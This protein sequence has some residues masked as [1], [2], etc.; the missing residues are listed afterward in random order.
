MTRSPQFAKVSRPNRGRG[1]RAIKRRESARRAV[2]GVRQIP[3]SQRDGKRVL[4]LSNATGLRGGV[5]SRRRIVRLW[6]PV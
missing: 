4:V 2:S 1:R 5:K 3:S 6:R